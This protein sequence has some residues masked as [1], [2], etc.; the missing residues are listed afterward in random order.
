[1]PC[2]IPGRKTGYRRIELITGQC[3]R[4]RWTAEEKVRIVAG[5]SEEGAS[6]SEVARRPGVA[7]ASVMQFIRVAVV[8][9]RTTGWQSLPLV[10]RRPYRRVLRPREPAVI[11]LAQLASALGPFVSIQSALQSPLRRAKTAPAASGIYRPAVR[12]EI[13]RIGFE[14][15]IPPTR[16]AARSG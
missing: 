11:L 2:L 9:R 15:A 13:R 12:Y 10:A 1:M 14:L 5:S 3:P 7:P 6:I 16:L 4:R 8:V